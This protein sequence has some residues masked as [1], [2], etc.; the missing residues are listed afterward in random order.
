MRRNNCKQVKIK[1]ITKLPEKL[2]TKTV[3]CKC[4]I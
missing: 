2:W 4:L 1:N 3:F